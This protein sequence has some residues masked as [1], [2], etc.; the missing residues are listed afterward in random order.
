MN[1]LLEVTDLS[2][3]FGGIRAL[4]G[5]SFSAGK[6]E[7]TAI[8]GP[9]GAG[10]TSP[11]NSISGFYKPSSGRVVFDGCNISTL[12]AHRRAGQLRDR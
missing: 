10:K 3:A 9:N 4:N 7:I 2:L 6:G 8:I 11:F 5:V 12:P 1:E